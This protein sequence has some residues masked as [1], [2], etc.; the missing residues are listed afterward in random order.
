MASELGRDGCVSAGCGTVTGTAV[1]ARTGLSSAIPLSQV[2]DVR[3]GVGPNNDVEFDFEMAPRVTVGYQG[4]DGLGVRARWWN[5]HHTASTLNPIAG[6]NNGISV[7]TYTLDLEVFDTV[8]LNCVWTAEIS[9]GIRISEFEEVMRLFPVAYREND[10]EGFGGVVGLELKRCIGE[11]SAVFARVRG[12][13]LMDDK[14]VANGAFF[15]ATG[16]F[17]GQADTLL[18]STQGMLE[19]ALGYEANWDLDYDAVMF[20]RISAEWQNWYNYSSAFDPIDNAG[21]FGGASDGLRR[22][23]GFAGIRVLVWKTGW[24]PTKPDGANSG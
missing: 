18:D 3:A 19:I 14:F 16:I 24:T 23:R 22:L 20:A 12:A 5:Y 17:V 8:Q 21:N 7:E 6:D 11:G 1:D 15:P 2:A 10:F 13:I 9:A 4:G